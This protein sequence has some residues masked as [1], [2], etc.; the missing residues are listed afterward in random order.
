[1]AN[2]KRP[3]WLQRFGSS[4]SLLSLLSLVI[5]PAGMSFNIPKAYAATYTV[6]S[7]SDSG[8]GTLRQAIL[9]AN[10][11]VGADSIT[12]DPSLAGST[13]TLTSPM[14]SITE[15]VSIDGSTSGGVVT[16]TGGF[17]S[18]VFNSGT[19]H[20]VTG[21]TLG[22]S[23]IV[24]QS[25]ASDV[26]IGGL[27]SLGLSLTAGSISIEGSDVDVI[28]V[29]TA[30]GFSAGAVIDVASTA[31]NVNLGSTSSGGGLDLTSSG[32]RPIQIG[33]DNVTLVNSDITYNGAD[34]L[35]AIEIEADAENTLIGG[36][37]SSERNVIGGT[38]TAPGIT[39]S[40]S[41]VTISGNYI[42]TNTDGTAADA[43]QTGIRIN[44]GDGITIG[45][46]TTAHGNVISGNTD[47]GIDIISGA[48]DITIQNNI[49]G[50]NASGLAAISNGGHGV[51]SQ[52]G[53]TLSD[54]I[55]S[56]NTTSAVSLRDE[57][58]SIDGVVVSGNK[59]G[60]DITGTSA[61]ANGQG[62]SLGS[63]F[64]AYTLTNVTVQNNLISGNTGKGLILQD[65]N[66]SPTANFNIWG[67]KIGTD[68]TGLLDMSNEG[69]ID[70]SASDIDMDASIDTSKRNIIVD[71]LEEGCIRFDGAS[72][73]VVKG[74]YCGVG[75]DGVT[76]FPGGIGIQVS[77]ESHTN[78]IG[79]ITSAEKNLIC[80]GEN[81]NINFG[82]GGSGD[83]NTF[84][85]NDAVCSV[86][87]PIVPFGDLVAPLIM[88][89][90]G[91][92]GN[93]G[94]DAPSVDAAT[95]T[96][97]SGSDACADCAVDLYAKNADNGGIYIDSATADGSG[98][99]S[100]TGLNLSGYTHVIATYTDA[101]GS[102]SPSSLTFAIASN[103]APSIG[104]VSAVAATDGSQSVTAT[105]SSL[106]DSDDDAL[107]LKVEYSVNGGDSWQSA[108]VSTPASGT[109]DNEDTYQISGLDTSSGAIS[110]FTFEWEAGVDASGVDVSNAR[111]RVTSSDAL[112]D[113]S[114]ASSADFE[115]DT[116]SPAAPSLSYAESF[117][118]NDLVVTGTGTE[119][120]S[121]IYID[122]VDTGTDTDGSGNLSVSITVLGSG[123]FTKTLTVVDSFGNTSSPALINST[124]VITTT[125]GTGAGG[126]GGSGGAS[127]SNSNNSTTPP[128][129]TEG[130]SMA[131]ENQNVVETPI[132]S[133]EEESVEEEVIPEEVVVEE[134]VT[135]EEVV[136]EEVVI[137]EEVTIEETPIVEPVV[138]VQTP[139]EIIVETPRDAF[140]DSEP[141]AQSSVTSSVATNSETFGEVTE[142]GV[143][144]I[145][146]Q[147]ATGGGRGAI[148]RFDPTGD[149]DN[150]G[151]YNYE[152]LLYFCDLSR[153][154]T[155]GDGLSDVQEIFGGTSCNSYD[156]DGDGLSDS[157]DAEPLS[158]QMPEV[159]S[160]VL[161]R[162]TEEYLASA[163]NSETA[164][165]IQ[166]ADTDGDGLSD[167]LELSLKTNPKEADSDKDG[168]EDGV[169]RSLYG[170]DPTT[171]T[172]KEEL[173]HLRFS[174]LNSCS[175][176]EQGGV[177]FVG[178]G[179]AN[180]PVFIYRVAEDG[181]QVL[182]GEAVSDERGVFQTLAY[183]FEPGE[184]N[185]F[186]TSGKTRRD[187]VQITPIA[188]IQVLENGGIAAP[189]LVENGLSG[190]RG[191]AQIA[192]N[193]EPGKELFVTWQSTVFSNVLIADA[194]QVS[195]NKALPQG[196]H[197][198]TWQARDLESGVCSSPEQRIFNV[199]H[200]GFVNLGA[201]EK[202][203]LSSF[204]GAALILASLAGLGYAFQKKRS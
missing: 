118:T 152:E 180:T 91:A 159:D 86:E 161:T 114:A 129:S 128:S 77:G 8:A 98:D 43:N 48:T 197:T 15:S 144:E 22:N 139:T 28:N 57:A 33:G 37:S 171:S 137:P 102:T 20:S 88:R 32:G 188:K 112:A 83:G 25:G 61:I 194:S 3:H 117:S 166:V 39:S 145:L 173:E 45:G 90:P 202:A 4:I 162:Y 134:K 69:G 110:N 151:V 204:L 169:E 36:S 38:A 108:T 199:T 81:I 185:V 143:P 87:V 150:D 40:G 183:G 104:T 65:D 181:E 68:V 193:T 19:A 1:M 163:E 184:N 5:F 179:L 11:N 174:N 133:S 56:G 50:L 123:S 73:S 120:T 116:A 121:N 62:I 136:V 93:N 23:S 96:S 70:S 80:S 122:G 67:N 176:V 170:T 125:G 63:T 195:L 9:D 7:T 101:D 154:D 44:G 141:A 142:Y 149:Q 130:E 182:V 66:P 54:N 111:L 2:T 115:L 92:T 21:L 140:V 6:T 26:T 27:G 175:A 95:G 31:S 24:V 167:W 147:L 49:I 198:V 100:F 165:S 18:F 200:A 42:G 119:A 53:F 51:S 52:V 35:P 168:L 72:Y 12:F 106:D 153:S 82:I 16:I 64:G 78:I 127:G 14:E 138:P 47:N 172:S 105:I 107:Q 13:I 75:A 46:A 126:S 94:Y 58:S 71:T 34:P 99:F 160:Q 196:D 201:A 59:V 85:G 164:P 148:D 189:S 131:G 10:A 191:T 155:D 55:I 156:S 79:G 158:Y 177:R 135:P 60:T 17:N 103:A 178:H 84:R 132:E 76:E 113:S 89:F 41:D 124:R 190:D 109:V 30:P 157:Q 74:N 29:S 192:L 97:V 186:A 187:I 146:V 203:P